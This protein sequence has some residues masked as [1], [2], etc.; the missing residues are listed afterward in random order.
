[1]PEKPR[2]LLVEPIHKHYDAILRKHCE[3]VRP[4]EANEAGIAAAAAD[5]DAILIRTKGAVTDKVLAAAPRLKV[6]ARHG[7][8]LD[9]ID[10]EAAA[11]RGV[12]VVYTPAG[13]LDAVA[14][15]TWMM[16]LALAK[17][18][19]RGDRAMRAIDFG[20]RSRHESLQ[21]KGKTLGVLGLGRIGTRVA[22]IAHRG[23]GMNVIYTDLLKFPAKEKKLKAR[24]VPLRTLLEKSDVLTVHVPL[25]PKTRGMLG[26]AEF[27]RMRP[28]AHLV[29]CARGAVMDGYAL[30]A[31]LQAG[32]LAGAGIDVFDPEVP[33]ADH[34]LLACET[35]VFSP[36]N[37]AQ[38][39]EA[40]FNYAAVV[41]DIL[42]VLSGKPP[43][44][45]ANQPK[46]SR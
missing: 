12:W 42:R 6:V 37:A 1:M 21:V 15:H 22:E 10:L 2:C 11:K 17:F 33:P 7:V 20:F 14:E 13:S 36:H 40:R 3:V 32:K 4:A 45:P 44:F 8:G 34:P 24:K 28:Q 25:T 31:A 30:A 35:A 26:A 9:H 29:N 39:A 18:T 41:E 38:T 16:I 46:P 43:K 23:F 19:C 5:C 27:A